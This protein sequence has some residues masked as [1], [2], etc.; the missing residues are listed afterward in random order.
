[1]SWLRY[2]PLPNSSR[3]YIRSMV[4]SCSS[5]SS[6]CQHT[7]HTIACQHTADNLNLS[8]HGRQPDNTEQTA[9]QHGIDCLLCLTD[10]LSVRAQLAPLVVLVTDSED[11][12]LLR[13]VEQTVV[14]RYDASLGDDNG[15]VDN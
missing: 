11:V 9:C 3:R 4:N 2:V 12:H 1:M 7:E 13:V 6:T 5:G 8:T 10:N 15:A 14:R